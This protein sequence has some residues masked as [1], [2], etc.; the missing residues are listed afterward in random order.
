MPKF[1][2]EH[3][4]PFLSE[5]CLI[6]YENI[7]KYVGKENLII[8]NLPKKDHKKL[9][10][11]AEFHEESV[12][13]MSLKNACLLEPQ[14]NQILTPQDNFEYFI[15]GGILGDHPERGRTEKY[16]TSKIKDS[17]LIQPQTRNLEKKQMSTDTAVLV[18]RM[19]AK[20]KIPFNKIPFIDEPAIT[21]KQG[22]IQEEI[23]LP[24]RYVKE[25]NAPKIAPKLLEYLKN[26]EDL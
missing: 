24:Y 6:E 12:L 19:I 5:W 16:L 17:K 1:I 8:T 13:T 4:E 21:L 14:T 11:L 7:S 20:D 3:L 9:A 15:F 18:T 26:K 23:I 2:I 22:N 10:K 25:N